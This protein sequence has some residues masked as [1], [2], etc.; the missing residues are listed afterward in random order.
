MK[1][2][3]NKSKDACKIGYKKVIDATSTAIRTIAGMYAE[4]FNDTF[5]SIICIT[6]GLT[7]IVGA[8]YLTNM[9]EE[10][11]CEYIGNKAVEAGSKFEKWLNRID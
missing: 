9:A 8:S 1:K 11:L 5:N 6:G 10:K 2:F 7:M 4:D 3:L